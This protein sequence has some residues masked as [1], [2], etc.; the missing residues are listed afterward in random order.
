MMTREQALERAGDV[1]SDG[2]FSDGK[3]LKERV[4]GLLLAAQA[5]T[6]DECAR[7]ADC[8]EGTDGPGGAIRLAFGRQG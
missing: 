3:W 7:I 5:K 4:A 8:Y 2:P 6:A 1:I